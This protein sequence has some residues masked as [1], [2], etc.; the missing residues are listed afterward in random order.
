M[1]SLTRGTPL[2]LSGLTRARTLGITSY[3]DKLYILERNSGT[4]TTS[5]YTLKAYS[6]TGTRES[7][8]DI[9]LSGTVPA[10]VVEPRLAQGFIGYT[11]ITING[12]K[13]YLLGYWS[14]GLTTNTQRAPDRYGVHRFSITGAYETTVSHFLREL[15]RQVSDIAIDGNSLFLTS[16]SRNRL[17]IY[18]L[19]T[20]VQIDTSVNI[21]ANLAISVTSNRI[22]I[23]SGTSLLA[24]NRSYNRVTGDDTSGFARN[25]INSSTINGTVFYGFRRRSQSV[26]PASGIPVSYADWGD[27]TYNASNRSF[28]IPITFDSIPSNFATSGFV[29][30]V[31]SGQSPNFTWADSTG[32]TLTSSGTGNTRTI[33]ATPGTF[34][35]VGGTYRLRLSEDA[36]GTDAPPNN[37]DSGSQLI[38]AAPFAVWGASLTYTASTRSFRG[39]IE[40]SGRQVILNADDIFG[41]QIRRGTPGSYT[42]HPSAPW[43]FD[44]VSTSDQR[45]DDPNNLNE[46]TVRATPTTSH[47]AGTYRLY[48]RHNAF[49]SMTPGIEIYSTEGEIQAFQFTATWRTP[50]YVTNRRPFWLSSTRVFNSTL[51]LN[52]AINI[53]EV[54]TS[55][56]KIQVRSGTVGSYTWTDSTGWTISHLAFNP[57]AV[58]TT[59][60]L[61]TSTPASTVVSGTYRLLVD[62]DAFGTDMPSGDVATE[63]VAIG[64]YISYYANWSGLSYRATSNIQS[65]NAYISFGGGFVGQPSPGHVLAN[66]PASAFTLEYFS[67]GTWSEATN[68]SIVLSATVISG[69]HSRFISAFALTPEGSTYLGSYPPGTYRFTLKEDALGTDQPDIDISSQSLTLRGEGDAIDG[70]FTTVPMGTQTSSTS[71]FVLTLNGSV[72]AS[73]LSI[74]D[75]STTNTNVTITSISPTTGNAAIYSVTVSHAAD[76]NGSYTLS[77]NANSIPGTSTYLSSPAS[78]I[79]SSSVTYDRRSQLTA[80]ISNVP[81]GIQTSTTITFTLTFNIAVPATDLTISDF[82]S[83]DSGVTITGVSPASGNQTGYTITVT[84][85]TSGSGSY[86]ISLNVNAIEASSTYLAGPAS[87]ITTN[88]ISYDT[89]PNVSVTSLTVPSGTQT[90]ASITATLDFNVDVD[91]LELTTADFSATAGAAITGTSPNS[92]DE[93]TYTLTIRQPTHSNGTYTIIVARNAIPSGGTYKQG[94]IVSYTSNAITYDTRQAIRVISFTAPSSTQNSATTNLILTLSRTV[95]AS[96]LV[97]SDFTPSGSATI[98]SIS[99]TSGNNS[100]YIIRINNPSS[101]SGTYTVNLNANAIETGTSYLQGPTALYTSETVTYDTRSDA[102]VS[103]F[104]APTGTQTGSTAALTLNFAHQIPAS[105]LDVRDFTPSSS[106]VV[107]SS[108]SPDTGNATTFTITVLQPLNTNGSYSISLNANTIPASTTYQA[109]PLSAYT[110][111]SVTFDTRALIQVTAFTIPSGIQTSSRVNLTLT[112]SRSIPASELETT[113]FSGT[114]GSSIRSISPSSGTQNTYTI[115][116]NQPARNSGTYR[117]TLSM[118]AISAGTDYGA[119]PARDYES[120]LI[121]YNTRVIATAAWSSVQFISGRLQGVLIFTGANIT[122]IEPTDFEILDENNRDQNWSFITPPNTATAGTGITIQATAP[123][124]IRGSFKINLK[125]NRVRSDGNASDNCPASSVETPLVLVDNRSAIQVSSFQGPTTLQ[126]RPEANFTLTFAQS[127]PASELSLSDFTS[128]LGTVTIDRITPISGSNLVYTITTIQPRGPANTYTL[129]LRQNSIMASTLYQEGPSTDIVSNSVAFNISTIIA[130]ASWSDESFSGGKL[131]AR[132]TF[133]GASITGLNASDFEVI[134]QND[135]R[136]VGWIFD[137]TEESISAGSFT[138]IRVTPPPE[139]SGFYK[140]KLRA[141][142]IRS[143]DSL[144]NNAPGIDIISDAVEIPLIRGWELLSSVISQNVIVQQN[145]WEDEPNDLTQ[146]YRYQPFINSSSLRIQS[147]V[148][149]IR[150]VREKMAQYSTIKGRETIIGELI[151]SGATSDSLPLLHAAY[152]QALDADWN[153]LDGNGQF[154]PA[155]VEVIDQMGDLRLTRAQRIN[156]DLS[157]VAHPVQ[158]TVQPLGTVSLSEPRA[159]IQ[160]WGKDFLGRDINEE[161]TYSRDDRLMAK[162]SLYY[163]STID[164]I[165]ALKTGTYSND[166]ISGWSSGNFTITARDTAVEVRFK[167]QDKKPVR[168]WAIEQTKGGKPYVYYGVIPSSYTFSIDKSSIR[169]DTISC[170]GRRGFVEQNLAGD[171]LR[172]VPGTGISY[173][174][175]TDISSLDTASKETYSNWQ[176][177]LQIGGEI[178]PLQSCTFTVSQNF[179]DSGIKTLSEYNAQPPINRSGRVIRVDATLIDYEGSTFYTKFKNNETLTGLEII[180][181]NQIEGN[182]PTEEIYHL[183]ESKIMHFQDPENPGTGPLILSLGIESIDTGNGGA[184]DLIISSKIPRYVPIMRYSV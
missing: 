138:T 155:T 91:A 46:H 99:P 78:A 129:T 33:T 39:V 89:R 30:Q 100:V 42:W 19:N 145:S 137:T 72:P 101:S 85:P 71:V 116:V 123:N 104:T 140:L 122:G 83:S 14:G 37:I 7:T 95:A 75:F 115:E 124:N 132:L 84:H 74:S 131:Q 180:Y 181:R 38:G 10:P 40:F 32:W 167:P 43:N 175:Q 73:E 36:F 127:I 63:A 64:P 26:Y 31:R 18:N 12:G 119:G 65:I 87:P 49:G 143:D 50:N 35:P 16:V 171:T 61:I 152:T 120:D 113:D 90:T 160:I 55:D 183:P 56:F 44:I 88:S 146:S 163:Y 77:L 92:G 159:S 27:N 121:S 153:I 48:L 110:S 165:F 170:L 20:G 158:L 150:T 66:T 6:L 179:E 128:S 162:T 173:P 79:T 59:S 176:A 147:D 51:I 102:T 125:V 58:T 34:L 76:S 67:G 15:T 114:N 2:F 70:S 17:Y 3:N 107:I 135:G 133:T 149:P 178:I 105:V 82:T 112:L 148:I 21:Q 157:A 57:L 144:I 109:G 13:I 96:A 103:S 47:P 172:S 23:M 98:A 9:S 54:Q 93:D 11:N 24:Y 86:T 166:D 106:S 161:I 118:N 154:F 182:F 108:I 139:I 117:I 136:T 184:N 142:S 156:D 134:T 45:L 60:I 69:V 5:S 168:F 22:Y 29:V 94:P 177:L 81:T 41:V 151:I 80:I 62:E 126:T 141:N 111:E 130:D 174:E 164:Y 68:Y 1:P 97:T 25:D 8:S 28:S 52:T 53:S 4:T 169:M